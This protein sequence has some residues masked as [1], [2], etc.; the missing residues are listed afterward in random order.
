MEAEEAEA[1]T[2]NLP[3]GCFTP[4]ASFRSTSCSSSSS[5]P[6]AFSSPSANAS[7]SASTSTSSS[8]PGDVA[9]GLSASPEPDTHEVH[10]LSRRLDMDTPL[11]ESALRPPLPLALPLFIEALS[12]D[13]AGVGGGWRR[14][15]AAGVAGAAN[16]AGAWNACCCICTSIRAH[17]NGDGGGDGDHVF[18]LLCCLSQLN[19]AN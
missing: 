15:P 6:P 18:E 2:R 19:N 9:Y 1:L 10:S 3:R 5:S 11:T 7:A 4:S 12:D 16:A 17:C 14:R 13:E 8:A